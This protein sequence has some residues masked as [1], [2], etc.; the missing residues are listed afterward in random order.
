[1]L[2]R[3]RIVKRILYAP[4]TILVLAVLVVVLVRGAFRAYQSE[5]ASQAQLQNIEQSASELSARESFLKQQTERL[6]SPRGL[7]EELRNK[8]PVAKQGEHVVIIVEPKEGSSNNVSTSSRGF[9]STIVNFF[10]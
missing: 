2:R 8:Y 9:W 7:E 4:I 5:R 1:M 6:Q 10:R 3:A